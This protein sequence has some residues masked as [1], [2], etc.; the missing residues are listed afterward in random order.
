MDKVQCLRGVAAMIEMLDLIGT[1]DGSDHALAKLI[2][3][4]EPEIREFCGYALSRFADDLY[5]KPGGGTSQ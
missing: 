2:V 4:Y 3:D 5:S 1:E